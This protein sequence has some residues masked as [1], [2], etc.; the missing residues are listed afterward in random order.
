MGI[1]FNL[2]LGDLFGI[3]TLFCIRLTISCKNTFYQN[4]DFQQ[5][6][7]FILTIDKQLTQQYR[8]SYS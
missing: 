8:Q 3:S 7:L 6:I 2:I 4:R 1:K 5:K